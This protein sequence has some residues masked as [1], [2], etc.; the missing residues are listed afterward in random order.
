MKAIALTNPGE[1][2]PFEYIDLELPDIQANEVLVKVKAFSINP[3]DVKTAKGTAFYGKL[4]EQDPIIL[5]W[6]IAGVVE[7]VGHEVD[8]MK[9][10]DAVFGMVNFPGHGMAYAEYVAAPSAHLA[11]KPDNI[12]FEEA[13]ATT[14]AA[15]TAW[16]D[17]TTQVD[18]NVNDK[19]L[20]HAASGGVGHFAVQIAKYFGA[21]VIG[22]SSA[23]NRNFVLDIGADE[24]LDY[25]EK[26]FEEELSH[27]D[28]VL[29]IVGGENI[30]KNLKVLR[31]G[32]TLISNLGLKEEVAT[33]AEKKG[34]KALA[35]LVQSRGEDMKE[36]AKLIEKGVLHAHVSHRFDFS[37]IR[38]AHAQVAT[39]HTV[40]KVVLSIVDSEV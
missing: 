21:Y 37:Q 30:P 25:Q 17:F 36:I 2:N 24:H 34:V 8:G 4:K 28:V 16:Q 32:G 26:Q 35:Y 38:E 40:G 31:E 15:L 23:A 18:L 29:D 27:I 33:E 11:H 13:A 5:G 7:K 14:L 10:G 19:V 6:D 3:V 39:G 9:V 20:I 12:T 1:D 22:T